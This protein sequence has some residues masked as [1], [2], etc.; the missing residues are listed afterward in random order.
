MCVLF[1]YFEEPYLHQNITT[2]IKTI[3]LIGEIGEDS[4]NAERLTPRVGWLYFPRNL[5]TPV[6]LDISL[7][8][9]FVVQ[10]VTVV[11]FNPYE[12]CSYLLIIP[13]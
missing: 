9:M 7:I 8:P 3:M 11:G 5:K 10:S 6:P 2:P 1:G 12:Y 13:L 4:S